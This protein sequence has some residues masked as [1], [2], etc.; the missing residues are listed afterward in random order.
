MKLVVVK[1][2]SYCVAFTD[3]SELAAALDTDLDPH[4]RS[5]VQ[6][7]A[8]L[9]LWLSFRASTMVTD[10]VATDTS[11]DGPAE[12]TVSGQIVEGMVQFRY[13]D[14]V[15]FLRRPV[16]PRPATLMSGLQ[17]QKRVGPAGRQ[18]LYLIY[19]NRLTLLRDTGTP[20]FYSKDIHLVMIQTTTSEIWQNCI[21][22]TRDVKIVSPELE[23]SKL[24][25]LFP[26]RK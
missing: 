16:G 20:R 4:S 3:F 25:Q 18:L 14:S 23:M 9:R 10:P 5:G 24:Y 15:R 2:D 26:Q 1:M 13:K 6:S 22:R 19:P 12:S 11:Q 17:L 8:V 7:T 21:N